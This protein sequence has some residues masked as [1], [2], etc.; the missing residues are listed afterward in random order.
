M[1]RR[2][3]VG[4]ESRTLGFSCVFLVPVLLSNPLVSIVLS[5]YPW[6]LLFT[7]VDGLGLSAFGLSAL[8]LAA[9]GLRLSFWMLGWF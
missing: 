6:L 1:G 8:R 4:I 7:R 5:Y 2:L 9:L 3:E